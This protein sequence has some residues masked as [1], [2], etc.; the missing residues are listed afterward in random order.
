MGSDNMDENLFENKF[1]KLP[2]WLIDIKGLQPADILV[3]CVAY[4][5]RSLSKK[6][7]R[8]NE[9]GRVYF[10]L[11]HD[12]LK[13]KLRLGRHQIM[14]SIKRLKNCG[15]IIADTE[16]KK[17]GEPVKYFLEM[18]ISKIRFDIT[19][20]NI[21]SAENETSQVP[22]LRPD[23]PDKKDSNVNDKVRTGL[24]GANIT[25][26]LKEKLMEYVDYR[27]RMGKKIEVYDSINLII[28]QIGSTFRDEQHLIDSI[29][30][31][32]MYGYQG[33]FPSKLK[34]VNTVE[35]NA[36]RRLR[37]LKEQRNGG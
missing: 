3:Y 25:P 14:N 10:Y 28:G 33:I 17:V 26:A 29:N 21:G 36:L 24:L 22:K 12:G 37:M 5:N 7:D 27:E 6:N 18:D 1:Y 32:F 9:E 4:N 34:R 30:A 8:V 19:S 31:T 13:K 35:S 11:T 23:K 20:P 15:V 16:K 2:K